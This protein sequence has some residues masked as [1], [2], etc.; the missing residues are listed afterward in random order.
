[1]TRITIIN[2]D[3]TI[4][5]SPSRI[6]ITNNPVAFVVANTVVAHIFGTLGNIETNTSEIGN[7]INTESVVGAGTNI[8]VINIDLA[9]FTGKSEYTRTAI[10]FLVASDIGE[11]SFGADFGNR[12]AFVTIK[13][14]C[15]NTIVGTRLIYAFTVVDTRFTESDTLIDIIGTSC[16]FPAAGTIACVVSGSINAGTVVRTS[17]IETVINIG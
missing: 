2:V 6:T 14:E 1:L 16:A 3:I 9:I 17:T 7:T 4:R 8:T 11:T 12:F 5:T 15:A 13:R 10:W